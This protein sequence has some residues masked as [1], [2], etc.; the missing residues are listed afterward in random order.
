M[1]IPSLD[2]FRK[3]LEGTPMAAEAD[4]IYNTSLKNNVNPAF[5]A[6]LAGAESGFGTK[7]FAVGTKNPYGWGVYPGGPGYN[8]RSY[9]EATDAL[10]KGLSG[11]TYFGAGKRSLS[12]VMNTYTPA[13]KD[14]S[15]QHMANIRSIGGRTGADASQVFVGSDGSINA[16]DTTGN[17]STATTIAQ[18]PDDSIELAVASRGKGESI[19]KSVMK[20]AVAAQF[21]TG[22]QG[23][24]SDPSY[25]QT[26][27]A[28]SESAGVGGGVGDGTVTGAALAQRGTPYS[29]GGGTPSGPTR[30][31]AQ[32]ANTV[33]F[34]CSSLVQYAWAK[35]GVSLPRTTYDQINVGQS[36]PNLS[37]ARPGDLLFPSTGHVQM[38]L[39]N[40]KVVEAPRTGGVVQVVPVRSNYIAIRRPG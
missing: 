23:T 27:N 25:L 18:T 32:G 15:N 39:G 40:G 24:A 14:P 9:T 21:G 1:A 26:Q 4:S 20:G 12:D 28:A 30:G 37:Q 33:G 19:F 31:F 8:Y 35:V 5:V 36:I 17:P 22:A 6:G 11:S 29:W 3:V 2:R 38:Y 10:T 34:D 7:G 13:T 16:T